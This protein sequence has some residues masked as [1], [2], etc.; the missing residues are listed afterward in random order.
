[1]KSKINN[2]DSVIDHIVTVKEYNSK[3]LV[4]RSEQSSVSEYSWKARGH[5]VWIQAIGEH[6]EKGVVEYTKKSTGMWFG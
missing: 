6:V 5:L 1:M 3:Q 4:G 2:S